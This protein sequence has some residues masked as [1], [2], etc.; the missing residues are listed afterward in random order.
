MS[1]Q[2]KSYYPSA[3]A[4]ERKWI[5]IDAA[6]QVLGRVAA[7]VAAIIRGKEKPEFT[8]SV[9]TGDFVIVVNTQKIRV[10]GK[11]ER[12]KKYHHFSG[13]PGGITT[14]G[15]SEL[16]KRNPT[17]ALEIAI[18]GM[19]PKGRLGRKMGTKFRLYP[20]LEHTQQAQNP[21]RIEIK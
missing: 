7:R 11:K 18:K 4:T 21:N 2:Q 3:N 19:L 6:D 9:D 16:M 17:K 12:E 8:P 5:L 13:H 15:Y 14:H 1:H 20:G 10:T